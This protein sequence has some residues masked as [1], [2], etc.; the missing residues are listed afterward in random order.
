VNEREADVLRLAVAGLTGP[1]IADRLFLS[2]RT[3]QTHMAAI[4][5]KLDVSTRGEA[6]RLAIER[7]L[8]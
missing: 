8:V 7:G 6:V 3:V 4:Y 5:R 2:P 1:Q